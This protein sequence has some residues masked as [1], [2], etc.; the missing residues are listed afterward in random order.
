MP[1]GIGIGNADTVQQ[2]ARFFGYKRSYLG[3]CRVYLEQGTLHAFQTYVEHEEDIRAQLE[4]FQESGQPL[5]EWKRVFV[6][7]AGLQPCRRHVLEFDYMRGRFSNDWVTPRVVLASDAV[8]QANQQTVAE[9]VRNLVFKEDDGHPDRT[10]VQRH[11]VCRDVPLRV[12]IEQ[13]LV[14]MRITGTT[15]SQRNTGLLLQVSKALEDDPDEVCTI[16][17]ISPVTGRRRGIDD[18]GGGD[19]PVSR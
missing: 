13:L 19:Q 6:L 15:D 3:Y 16:Y 7:D 8:V 17:R 4:E 2:R 11:H 12:V 1:R 14:K 18:N 9:F 10:D 5:N